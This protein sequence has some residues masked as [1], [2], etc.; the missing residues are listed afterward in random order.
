[1]T[2][3]NPGDRVR[4]KPGA[5][6]GGG[7]PSRKELIGKTGV[8]VEVDHA[9]PTEVGVRVDG[10]PSVFSA[11]GTY[12]DRSSLELVDDSPFIVV[13][14]CNNPEE[15]IVTEHKTRESADAEVAAVKNV[16]PK[17]EV[18]IAKVV[19]S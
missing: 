5:T 6:Y 11:G 4:V 10:D 2:D 9:G 8:I 13:Y 3:F 12:F 15:V 19:V 14:R 17:Y 16:W 18:T 7:T 1:M